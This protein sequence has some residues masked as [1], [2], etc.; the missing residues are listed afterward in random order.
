MY[1]ENLQAKRNVKDES[2]RTY[3]NE[4]AGGIVFSLLSQE[5]RQWQNSSDEKKRG[6]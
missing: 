5:I 2:K 4:W 1:K 6:K 3:S